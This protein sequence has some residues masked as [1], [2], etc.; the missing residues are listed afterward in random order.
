M[1][2]LCVWVFMYAVRV[3]VRV[4]GEQLEYTQGFP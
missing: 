4:R 1:S 2:I 3:R